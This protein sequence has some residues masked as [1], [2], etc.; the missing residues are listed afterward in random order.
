MKKTI[1]MLLMFVL[2]LSLLSA[3]G[4][5]NETSGESSSEASSEQEQESSSESSEKPEVVTIYVSV[6]DWGGS[7]EVTSDG[8]DPQIDPEYPM[9]SAYVNAPI[10][11]TVKILGEP[12]EGYHF[13]RWTVDGVE[14]STDALLTVTAE[15][16]TEFVA[17]F[18]PEG[19]DGKH[20]DLDKVTTLGE[21]LGLMDIGY[22]LFGSTYI[23]A[24]EQD[25]N[26]Y[27]ALCDVTEETSQA[28]FDLD[29]NDPDYNAKERELLS[30]LPVKSIENLTEGIP[31]QEEADQ[32]IGKTGQELI[33]EGWSVWYTNLE[34]MEF[35]MNHGVYGFTI[36]FDG[37][38]PDPDNF[39]EETDMAGLTVRSIT[40]DGVSDATYMPEE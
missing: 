7:I 14:Y 36:Q 12:E 40:C 25:G 20:V 11:A 19:K 34:E 29:F 10:G 32:Y 30:P 24:F 13:V 33:D 3:C 4:K 21:L 18:L 6:K 5:K 27:R 28:I 38:I 31:S 17:E 26:T 8:T 9:Q 39:N 37:E 23:Y 16:Q 22:S 2:V 35:G 1:A 15:K